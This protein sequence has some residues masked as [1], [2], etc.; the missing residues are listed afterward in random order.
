MHSVCIQSAIRC[1][2]V[3]RHANDD[4]ASMSPVPTRRAV[5]MMVLAR[6]LP[7]ESSGLRGSSCLCLEV[8]V[9]VSGDREANI[10]EEYSK[11]NVYETLTYSHW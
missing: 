8:V 7:Q 3:A 9:D 10:Y 6:S 2:F 4:A 1:R 11:S 5:F